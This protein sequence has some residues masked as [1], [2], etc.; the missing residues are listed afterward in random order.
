MKPRWTPFHRSPIEPQDLSE[1][2]ILSED[3]EFKIYVNSRYQ[4]LISRIWGEYEDGSR[5]EVP[6][7][8]LSIKRHDKLPIHDW[9]DLQ[10][11]KNDLCGPESLA[12][13]FYPPES[14]LV[15]TANQY[16]LWVL[17]ERYHRLLG[18]MF[19][20][21]VVSEMSVG[22]SHQRPWPADEKPRDLETQ[23]TLQARLDAMGIKREIRSPE[24]KS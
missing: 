7:L 15:D 4:V 10:R 8:Q 9:R 24:N 17:P 13:E 2:Q 22:G 19:H 14:K 16:F 12:I 18:F 5:P 1:R 20:L 21:R 23:E 11:I 6:I 3:P